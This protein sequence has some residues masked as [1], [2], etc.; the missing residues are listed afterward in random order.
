MIEFVLVVLASFLAAIVFTPLVR[1]M[2]H[3]YGIVDH[4]DPTRKLH[5]RTVARAG[6]VAVLMAVLVACAGALL[7][8]NT[9]LLR[10][11]VTPYL[12][13][14]TVMIGVMLLGLADDIWTL[15]G[16]QKLLGQVVL[17]CILAFTG[18]RIGHLQ[19]FGISF[20]LGL[21]SIPVT[22]VWL[23]ATTNALNLIDGSDG[24]CTS[25]GAVISAAL[26]I[27][28]SMNGHF[29]EAAIAFALCGA[30]LGFLV[31]NFPP[32][33]I[34]LGDSGS[35]LIG[36]ITGALA[37]RCS[38][39]GPTAVA[40]LAP[41]AILSIPLLDSSMAI[42]RR[43]LTGRSIYTTDRAHLHHSLKDKGLSDHGLV[44][45]VILMAI[46]TAAGAI[47]GQILGRDWLAL[48]GTGIVFAM[49]VLTR[50][51]GHAELVLVGRRASNFLRSLTEPAVKTDQIVHHKAVRLQGTR[52]WE[53]IWHTMVEFAESEQLCKFHMDL[54]IPWLHEGFH[55]SWHRSRQLDRLE[56]WSTCL[57]IFTDGRIV[58]RVEVSGPA[59]HGSTLL[60]VGKLLELLEDITP[61]VQA[62][63]DENKVA[64]ETT[65]VPSKLLV[66]LNSDSHPPSG[67][68][69]ASGI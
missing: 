68:L 11:D 29:A 48:I 40:F 7:R 24:L 18:F 19:I 35:L 37:I 52:E 26:G 20:D 10:L 65:S 58:G 21:L 27:V 39:K 36:M 30:L 4:P 16:R 3:R 56:R 31:F 38:I 61:Q 25:L 43:K 2:A 59:N 63:L 13:L 64:E 22:L 15:R 45:A 23:L 54:N 8:F 28:S 17:A 32:A 60:V 9:G 69:S 62:I 51:F 1:R 14:F 57:P 12:G 46:I 47:A 5:G 67:E 50:A 41:L 49:L 66:E 42:L 53:T 55:G 33:S 6:G 34:F 44:F